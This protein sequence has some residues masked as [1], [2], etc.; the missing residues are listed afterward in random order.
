MSKPLVSVSMVTYNHEKYIAAAIES[1]VSQNVDFEI[2]L[3][4]GEDCSS[5][6][7]R[8][9]CKEYARNYPTTIRLLEN[10]RNLGMAANSMRTIQHCRGKYVANLDGDDIWND[11]N[12]LTAQ[13]KFLEENQEFGMVYSNFQAIDH[14]SKVIDYYRIEEIRSQFSEGQL[15]FKL[16]H[17]NFIPSCTTMYRKEL[18]NLDDAD[19]Q[20]FWF[21][22]DFWYWLQ[23]AMKSKIHYM[24]KVFA[25][26]RLHEGGI[27]SSDEYVTNTRR[28]YF[29]YYDVLMNFSK[30][31]KAK[32]NSK[33]KKAVCKRLLYLLNGRHGTPSMKA[34]VM[35]LLLKYY[36]GIKNSIELI[37]KEHV[38]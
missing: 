33:E 27:T 17:T 26:W 38:S 25:S 4:I 24:D 28:P 9:I 15:F 22:Q 23:I 12:K 7:T 16:L 34:E 21:L 36:P 6:G 20:Q 32:L 8:V 2:E 29:I 18:I 10:D 13:V 19:H 11:Q 37:R 5:D 31:Y 35:K 3:V 1:V 30:T 14:E